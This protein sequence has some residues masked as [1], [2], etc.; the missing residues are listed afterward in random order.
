M[1]MG[2]LDGPPFS[3]PMNSVA[4]T[5]SPFTSHNRNGKSIAE[6]LSSFDV[7]FFNIPPVTANDRVG[8]RGESLSTSE[9]ASSEPFFIR[10]A[11]MPSLREI[12]ALNSVPTLSSTSSFQTQQQEMRSSSQQLLAHVQNF[13]TAIFITQTQIAGVSSA[14]AEYLAWLRQNSTLP[15][16]PT[17]SL[18]VLET[19]ETR[20]REVHEM[21]EEKHW[22]AW[23]QLV[24]QLHGIDGGSCSE[25]LGEMEAVMRQRTAEAA[26][27]F[28][29]NYDVGKTVQEQ[30]IRPQQE[31]VPRSRDR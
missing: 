17:D 25:A 15:K 2:P 4:S 22:V 20:V 14:V 16:V 18:A 26:Q 8:Y 21:A 6:S 3:A 28:H 10:G 19:L 5:P 1:N 31:G 9:D 12:R 7:D 30:M 13:S 29:D 23:K 11:K 24:E 27:D